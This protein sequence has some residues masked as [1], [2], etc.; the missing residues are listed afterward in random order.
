MSMSR[1]DVDSLYDSMRDAH[2][3]IQSA[4]D[5]GGGSSKG[6]V[7]KVVQALEVG[8]GAAGVGILAGR[9]QT[10]SVGNSG[11]PLG[12]VL[13]FAGHAAAFFDLTGKYE[14]H[15]TNVANGAFAGWLAMWGAG[16][17]LQMRQKAGLNI[18]PITAG[19]A[20]QAPP[21]LGAGG[22]SAPSRA[23]TEAELAALGARRW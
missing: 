5:G 9:L 10:T 1:R 6:I 23:L 17:G 8:A 19:T 2:S 12:L 22:V 16:Q 13:G 20:E 4:R 14:E 21:Q 15:V 7:N 18:G 11:V 3:Y